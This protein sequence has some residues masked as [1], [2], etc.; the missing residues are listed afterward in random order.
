MP[1]I[2]LGLHILIALFFAVHVIRSGQQMYWLIVLLSFPLLGSIVYF[3]AVYLPD[4]RLERGAR[5]TVAAVVKSMDPERELREARADF[6]YT[7]SAQNQMRLAKALLEANAASDAAKHYEAC[8]K[9]PF[10]ADPEIKFCAARAFFESGQFAV[11]MVHLESLRAA[12]PDFRSAEVSILTARALA[13]AGQHQ[14]AKREFEYASGRFGGFEVIAEY[15]IWA[16]NAGDWA[17]ADRLQPDLAEAMKR[18]NKHTRE[19]NA[20]LV[21][22]LNSATNA[23]NKGTQVRSAQ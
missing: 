12:D 15:A 22:R 3:V 1:F 4:S 10:A 8:L 23:A 16:M 20:Q 7:P 2:G 11:A 19:L 6:D 14:E 17:T 5:K 21:G 13:A 9:G 18:W